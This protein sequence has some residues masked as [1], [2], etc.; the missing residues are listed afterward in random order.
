MNDTTRLLDA[1]KLLEYFKISSPP[2][3][4]KIRIGNYVLKNEKLGKSNL[5][6]FTDSLD[7]S[8]AFE[9]AFR[10]KYDTALVFRHTHNDLT[11]I[12][13]ES[14]TIVK[15]DFLNMSFFPL[16]EAGFLSRFDQIL[17]TL[18][19]LPTHLCLYIEVLDKLKTLFSIAHIH[20]NNDAGVTN[21][22]GVKVPHT[23]EIL[24]TKN[25]HERILTNLFAGP[26]SCGEK[27]L[28]LPMN[29][30]SPSNPM[31]PDIYITLPYKEYYFSLSTIPSR[32]GNIKK[33]IDSLCSQILKPKKIFLHIPHEYRRFP[34]TAFTIPD[35]SDND[36]VEIVRCKDYGSSTKFLPM[37]LIE[38]VKCDDN[39]IIVDDDHKYDPL[40]SVKLLDLIDRYPDSASC[41]FG[42][43]NALYF[44]DRTWNTNSNTQNIPS[45]FRGHKEGY[46]DVF[47]GFGGV[48]LQ[49]RFF[50][51][52]VMF[53]P[54]SDVYAHDD[55]WFS[56]QVIKNGY[57]IVVS[58]ENV[59]NI[60]F[61]DKID[62]LCLDANTFTKSSNI[63]K[64][65][66]ENYHLYL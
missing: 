37:M 39:I 45:G 10:E 62:A 49:K 12:Q 16:L 57:K 55:I 38:E 18:H 42:V 1:V 14:N 17:M 21:I 41:M 40:L 25:T 28:S 6:S 24:F 43:T 23:V 35:F 19:D 58:G 50:T 13:T 65:I 29:I 15:L 36:L 4:N 56:V 63:M 26:Y 61:Q 47:E 33:V 52:E 59:S 11:I 20:C 31:K 30:D 44:K 66:Q 3:Q 64:Y 51:N 7:S 34:N 53:F 32:M 54:L 46:I 8:S 9:D 5:H 60:P 48:C 22:N 2:Q 27:A